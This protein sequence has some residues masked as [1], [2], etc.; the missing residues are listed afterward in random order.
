MLKSRQTL[1][2]WGFGGSSGLCWEPGSWRTLQLKQILTT[3]W[4]KNEKKCWQWKS[5]QAKTGA[6]RVCMK[7]IYVSVYSQQCPLGEW[8]ALRIPD[9]CWLAVRRSQSNLIIM[10]GSPLGRR[11][12]QT[13]R[14][15]PQKRFFS[16]SI[17][18]N[19]V[20]L[21]SEPCW[22]GGWM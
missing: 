12:K 7:Q 14:M 21:I 17:E 16:T 20:N 6:P 19:I 9:G 8:E 15:S 10:Q 1:L 5:G 3:V 2:V 22:L 11:P 13:Y 4:K 18:T